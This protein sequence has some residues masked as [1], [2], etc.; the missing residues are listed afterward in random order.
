M[1]C[2]RTFAGN[3]GGDVVAVAEIDSIADT[4]AEDRN[5]WPL[6]E[7]VGNCLV[8]WKLAFPRDW[9]IAIAVEMQLAAVV[10]DAD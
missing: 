7:A 2:T 4:V 9:R 10:A 1:R 3:T 8:R 5:Y 6:A